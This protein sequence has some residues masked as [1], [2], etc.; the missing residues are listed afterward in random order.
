[1]RNDKKISKTVQSIRQLADDFAVMEKTLGNQ[2]ASTDRIVESI[3]K[4][5]EVLKGLYESNFNQNHVPEEKKFHSH[6]AY[7]D[8]EDCWEALQKS[9][10]LKELQETLDKMPRWSGEWVWFVDNGT[11]TV[12]RAD[13][14][15]TGYMVDDFEQ[16]DIANLSDDNEQEDEQNV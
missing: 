1:M 3:V 5:A 6:Q 11:V 16:R 14:D 9:T 7:G 12:R 10:S 4:S 8:I 2:C 15:D 13:L